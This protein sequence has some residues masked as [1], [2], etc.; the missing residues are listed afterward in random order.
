MIS[1]KSHRRKDTLFEINNMT[2][3]KTYQVIQKLKN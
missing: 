3:F 1:L 2:I